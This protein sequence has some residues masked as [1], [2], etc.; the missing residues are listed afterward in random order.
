MITSPKVFYAERSCSPEPPSPR[1]SELLKRSSEVLA[2]V[3]KAPLGFMLSPGF[4]SCRSPGVWIVDAYK[5]RAISPV[6]LEILKRNST[7]CTVH[8]ACLM[9]SVLH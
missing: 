2:L 6:R 3:N 5:F 7:K 1:L 4:S 9:A 8:T